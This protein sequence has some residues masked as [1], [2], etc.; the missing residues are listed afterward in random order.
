MALTTDSCVLVAGGWTLIGAA[1]VHA[2]HRRGFSHV[3]APSAEECPPTDAGRVDAY[4]R[5]RRPN[6]VF[7]AAGRSGGIAAN[8]RYPAD[9]ML[10]NLLATTAL[11]TAARAHG[12]EKLLYLGS[13]CCYP[14]A[15]PQPMQVEYLGTGPLEPTSAPY[16]TAK[17]AG[18]EL[19]RAMRLQHGAPFLAGIPADVFGPSSTFDLENSHV[20]PAIIARMHAAKQAGVGSIAL[21]GTGKPRREFLFADDL[22]D[23][24][25]VVMDRYDGDDPINLGG[26]TELS[27]AEAA[28]IIAE[29]VGYRGGIEWD[30]SRPDGAARK[31]LESTQLANLGWR[32]ATPFPEAVRKTYGVLIDRSLQLADGRRSLDGW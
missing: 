32:A 21:W 3:L 17:L 4:F 9:L 10:D 2:L 8:R 16:A 19:C 24:C 18:M 31:L 13:S 7:V 30:A 15:C 25:L 27:I 6:H 1:L 23:A 5:E 22:A 12:V 26:G 20:I 14:A 28:G 11:L 29:V